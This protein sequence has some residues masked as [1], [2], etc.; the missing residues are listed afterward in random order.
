MGIIDVKIPM[1]ESE[2]QELKL[3]D[4][5]KFGC[6]ILEI[7]TTLSSCS[8]ILFLPHN[9]SLTKVEEVFGRKPNNGPQPV[10]EAQPVAVLDQVINQLQQLSIRTR[11][12][13]FMPRFVNTLC[14]K[15][16]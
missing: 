8:L 2:P 11:V 12:K 9:S 13:V 7:P 4:S 14:L 5:D 3:I 6:L 15:S 10:S 1:M 16:F